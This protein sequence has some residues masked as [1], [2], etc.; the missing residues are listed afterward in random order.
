MRCDIQLETPAGGVAL[1]DWLGEAAR[2][3]IKH[4]TGPYLSP[5]P[6]HGP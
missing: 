5:D 4:D 3:M 2:V 1:A 6:W